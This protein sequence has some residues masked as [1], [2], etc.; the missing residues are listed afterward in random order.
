MVVQEGDAI[1]RTV[2]TAGIWT[3]F[4]GIWE[5]VIRGEIIAHAKIP[6]VPV[7]KRP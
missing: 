4:P 7:G 6:S 3:I 1:P 5:F 2:A